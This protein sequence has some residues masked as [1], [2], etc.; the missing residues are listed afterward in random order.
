MRGFSE[1]CFSNKKQFGN[2]KSLGFKTIKLELVPTRIGKVIYPSFFRNSVAKIL[3][4]II[5]QIHVYLEAP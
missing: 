3:G 5:G 4:G 2:S 1:E